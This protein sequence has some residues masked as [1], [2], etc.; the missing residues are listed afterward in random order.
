M[1]TYVM[2]GITILLAVSHGYAYVTGGKHKDNEW[3]AAELV[4]VE[5]ARV[6]EKMW[7]GV[8]NET[9]KNWIVKNAATQ[10]S[11]DIA[12]DS[13][14]DRPSRLPD[15]ARTDCKGTTGREL[16]A[17]DGQFLAREAARADRHRTALEACY[18]YADKL[19]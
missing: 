11:L 17:E 2:L 14:H 15:T 1:N 10:R 13:L 16:S 6:T 3:K 12:L 5:Q 19:K 7:Q 18:A 8:V 4:K 9:N